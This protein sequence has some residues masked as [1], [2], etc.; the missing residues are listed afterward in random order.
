MP[1]TAPAMAPMSSA[2]SV[3]HFLVRHH[4]LLAQAAALAWAASAAC[5]CCLTAATRLS[6]VKMTRV[7]PSALA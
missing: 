6:S 3:A 1:V 2:W 5:C 4:Q 7:L